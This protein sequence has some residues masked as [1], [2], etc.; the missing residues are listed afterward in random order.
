MNEVLS[1]LSGLLCHIDDIG[2]LEYPRGTWLK[3]SGSSKA[4]GIT[5][6]GNKC[7]FLQP[8]ITFLGHVIDKQGISPD[9]RKT[10]AIS[11]MKPPSFI[12]ELRRFM[13]MVNQMSK[14]SSNIVQISKPLCDLLSTRILGHGL[15]PKKNP[16]GNL[17][18]KFLS[19]EIVVF[20]VWCDSKNH[21]HCRGI[22]LWLRSRP[23]TTARR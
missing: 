3:I 14:F 4:A 20:A 13:G 22:C 8:R 18:K 11:A 15:L 16:L 5:L 6:N 10:A 2:F 17:K 9:P 7:Q 23:P 19:P 12:T 1:D 21:N